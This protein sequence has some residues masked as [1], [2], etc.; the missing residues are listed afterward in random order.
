M[1]AAGTDEPREDMEQ[2]CLPVAHPE[3]PALPSSSRRLRWRRFRRW[4]LVV[5]ATLVVAGI[6]GVPVYVRPQIDPLRHAD[7]IFIVGGPGW[8]RYSV[9]FEL[10]MQGWAPAVALSNPIGPKDPWLTKFC[11]DSHP[12]ALHCFIPD[13]PTTKGEARELRRLA[14]EFNWKSV[15]VVTF[16]PH[17]S[18]A[19]YILE[20]CFDGNLI[21]VASPKDLSPADWAFEYAYQTAGY[22]RAALQPGC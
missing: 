18:R 5:C 6:A 20:Q 21:M 10:A 9:G 17:I 3:S 2:A 4:V 1:T 19:R 8:N 15:I 22:I 12:I 16:T 11:A 14:T 13:P 7:A